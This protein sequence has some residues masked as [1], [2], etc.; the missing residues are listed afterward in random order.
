MV[1]VSEAIKA[2]IM[3]AVPLLV[4]VLGYINTG[5]LDAYEFANGAVALIGAVLVY[6]VRNADEGW[7]RFAKFIAAASTTL[8]VAVVTSFLTGEWNAVEWKVL[9]TGFVTT[10]LVYFATNVVVLD[11]SGGVRTVARPVEDETRRR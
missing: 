9:L 11:T 6:L 10:V 4:A 7:Q 1:V 8:V 3:L 2:L 5:T